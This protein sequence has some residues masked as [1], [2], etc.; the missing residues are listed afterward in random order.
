MRR[1]VAV[2]CVIAA[3][4]CATA[5]GGTQS[6]TSAPKDAA[7][8]GSSAPASVATV[9]GSPLPS[10]AGSQQANVIVEASGL[11]V[12]GKQV[13]YG[14]VL[15][16]TSTDLDATMVKVTCN[17][18][19]GSGAILNTRIETLGLVPAGKQ[20]YYGGD[21]QGP[22][23]AQARKLEAYVDVGESIPAQY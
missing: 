4:L 17:L 20:F 5:C 23:G 2:F 7:P 16:N 11:S 6:N 3:T 19:D 22:D 9:T 15:R 13:G 14:L 21:Y 1:S 12:R 8:S 10:S 18:L